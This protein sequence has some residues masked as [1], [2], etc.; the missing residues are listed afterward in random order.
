MQPR[1][2]MRFEPRSWQL[3]A[4][5]P[6]MFL[7]GGDAKTPYLDLK[8]QENYQKNPC[9]NPAMLACDA[10]SWYVVLT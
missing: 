7:C 9:R 10:Y 5:D 4:S 1:C 3:L 2:A 8:S 6:K